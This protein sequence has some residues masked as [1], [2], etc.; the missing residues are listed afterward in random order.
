MIAMEKDQECHRH[1]LYLFVN[2]IYEIDV[3]VKNKY[4]NKIF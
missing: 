2:C 1:A 3:S 4:M